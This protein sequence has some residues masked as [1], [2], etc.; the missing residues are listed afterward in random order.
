MGAVRPDR[1]RRS[2]IPV[3]MAGNLERHGHITAVIIAGV[4]AADE[5]KISRHE[6][7][8]VV[9]HLYIEEKY[10]NILYI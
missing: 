9:Q 6:L 4:L 3:A 7:T 5:P 2:I 1:V 8:T 10:I